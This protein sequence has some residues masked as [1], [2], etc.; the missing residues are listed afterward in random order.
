M[1]IQILTLC[2]LIAGCGASASLIPTVDDSGSDNVPDSADPVETGAPDSSSIE[3]GDDSSNPVTDSGVDSSNT[4]DAGTTDSGTPDSGVTDGGSCHDASVDVVDPCS[5]VVCP[6][7]EVCDNGKCVCD[8]K[9]PVDDAGC[10]SKCDESKTLLCH[11][12]PGN[13]G[14]KHNICVGNAAVLA[15]LDH[16][17]TLG[18]CSN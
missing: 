15:H 16:G 7:G 4:P 3:A 6:Q 1:R 18:C 8:G 5:N 17:D 12:P 13:W 10:E 11:Y 2:L 9:P 14:N